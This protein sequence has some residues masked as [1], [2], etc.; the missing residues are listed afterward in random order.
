VPTYAP[1]PSST[2]YAL[3]HEWLTNVP[4]DAPYG[5][6]RRRL[7]YF[8]FTE[9]LGKYSGL[10]TADTSSIPPTSPARPRKL[11]HASD[12]STVERT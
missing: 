6:W 10:K 5:G 12:E 3:F 7:N 11:P 2:N 4:P 1:L 9:L 8:R